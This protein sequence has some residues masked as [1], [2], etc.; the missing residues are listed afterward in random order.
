MKG[1]VYYADYETEILDTWIDITAER[2]K[3]EIELIAKEGYVGLDNLPVKEICEMFFDIVNPWEHSEF[4]KV[5]VIDSN[6]K[7]IYTWINNYKKAKAFV[8]K[9]SFANRNTASHICGELIDDKLICLKGE[10]YRPSIKE[11]IYSSDR[12]DNVSLSDAK[13]KELIELDR[14]DILE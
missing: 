2:L 11:G 8:V 5:I 7:E 13:I 1:K 6:S 4:A 3:N 14:I 12:L 10:I 9:E